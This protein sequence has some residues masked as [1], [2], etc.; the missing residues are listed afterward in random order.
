MP[1]VMCWRLFISHTLEIRLPAVRLSDLAYEL[2]PGHVDGAINSGRVRPR[3]VL[4]NLDHQARVVGGDHACLQHA[5]EPDVALGLAE[6]PAGVDSSTGRIDRARY[7]LIVKGI[8]CRT[9]D[10]EESD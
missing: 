5:Q 10:D 1:S 2:R 9:V 6:R 3:V 4:Q 7:P 8:H